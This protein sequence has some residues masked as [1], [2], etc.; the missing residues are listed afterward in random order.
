MAEQSERRLFGRQRRA[1]SDVPRDRRYVVKVNADEDAKLQA[2]AVVAGV[3]VPRLMFEAGMNAHVET[4]TERKQALAELFAVSR[5]LGTVAN[6]VN[7]LARYA[8]TEGRFP[9]EAEAVVAEYREL[10][11]RID[12]TIRRLAGA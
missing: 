6:N 10:T 9:D 1:N 11:A 3:T 4:S 5:T 8:N 2:R 12:E 7:Q